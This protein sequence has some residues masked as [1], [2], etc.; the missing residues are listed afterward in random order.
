MSIKNYYHCDPSDVSV[1]TLPSLERDQTTHW[2]L[3]SK[4]YILQV[5]E[6]NIFIKITEA[7]CVKLQ[8]YM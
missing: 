8:I 1:E 5:T 6:E 7:G 2:A 4:C 3:C